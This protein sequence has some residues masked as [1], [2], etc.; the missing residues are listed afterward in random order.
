ML[1]G[2]DVV[3]SEEVKERARRG[4]RRKKAR[5]AAAAKSMTGLDEVKSPIPL[6]L[7]LMLLLCFAG[8]TYM[9]TIVVLGP[10][11]PVVNGCF[12]IFLLFKMCSGLS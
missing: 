5:E 1:A 8:Y 11:V 2:R 4:V 10:V 6:G 3:V 7:M 9:G 12:M